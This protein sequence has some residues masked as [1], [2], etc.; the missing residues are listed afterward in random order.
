D[1]GPV[2]SST[3]LQR[4]S[5]VLERAR[6]AGY[7]CLSPH[8]EQ[9]HAGD[10]VSAGWYVA[11]AIVVCDN[12]QAEIVQEE[13]FGPVLVVQ[14]ADDFEQALTL[15]NGVTQGLVAALFSGAPDRQAQFLAQAQAGM[16]KINQAT[17]GAASGAPFGGWKASGVGPPEHGVGDLEFFTRHQTIYQNLS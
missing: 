5:G 15:C 10:W 13:T 4:I 7:S 16:L 14:P 2:I 1:V 17:A 6:G 11:P 9:S 12:P 8:T 3:A